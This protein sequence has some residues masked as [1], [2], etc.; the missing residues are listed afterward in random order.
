MA[1]LRSSASRTKANTSAPTK[2][3]KRTKKAKSEPTTIIDDIDLDLYGPE[4]VDEDDEESEEEEDVEMGSDAPMG[5]VDMEDMQSK[6]KAAMANPEGKSVQ[7]THWCLIYR[8]DGALEVS[9]SGQGFIAFMRR[10]LLSEV[11]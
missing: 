8:S 6:A 10:C 5:D 4:P 7:A 2:P 1:S 9:E 11:C 3:K